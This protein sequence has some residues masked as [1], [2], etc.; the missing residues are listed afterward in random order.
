M[1][2]INDSYQLYLDRLNCQDILYYAGYR[3]NRRDGLRYPSFSRLDNEGRRIRGDKFICMPGGKTCFKP[4]VIK[5]YN[6]ISLIKSFPEMFPE[7]AQ[8]KSDT[9]L[10]HAVCRSILNMPP[11]EKQQH[12]LEPLKAQK[13]FDIKD[14]DVQSFQKYNAGS[15]KKFRPYFRER[16]LSTATLR[17]FGKDL[18]LTTKKPEEKGRKTYTNLSFP[19]TIPGKEGIVGLEERGRARLDGTSGYKGKALGSNGSEGL[20]ISSPYGT[21]LQ[22]AKHVMWFESGYDAMAFHQLLTSGKSELSDK[23]KDALNRAVYISTGGN[24]TVMQFRGVIKQAQHAE[25]HLCFDNDLAGKQYVVNFDNELRHVRE[26][27]PKVGRDMK[28]FM[29]SLKRPNDYL[30]GKPEL[31]PDD[32]YEHYSDY[33]DAADELSSMKSARPPYYPDDIKEQQAKVV[34]LHNAFEQKVN[35]RLCIGSEQGSLKDLGTYDIPEWAL[36]AMENG[37]YEGLTD[38]ETKVLNDF[39]KKHFPD[40]FVSS[41]DW[42]NPNDFN[43]LPAFGTRNPNASPQYGESPYQAVKT[44]PVQ[45]LHPTEREAYALPDVKVI[46][47][48]PDEGCKDFNE[49]LQKQ[50][51]EERL[52]KEQAKED[53]EKVSNGL[54]MDADGDIEI[55]ESEEKKHH[56]SMGR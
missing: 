35:E 22:D 13:P 56:H 46:R 27:M 39:M 43:V 1:N 10:V 38:E 11:E 23:D 25:H 20:W 16:G 28:E 14:Y 19:L 30:S 48:E 29:D 52:A 47:E 40:G 53:D 26:S 31:L 41:I 49:Q 34:E 36:C 6:V 12:M 3:Q 33:V 54:D 21:K 24:P 5:S 45:F 55:T 8:G 7:S 37:D 9:A 50:N 17:T 32:L 15:Y 44:Y 18:M 42:N 2:D 51:E 4:P